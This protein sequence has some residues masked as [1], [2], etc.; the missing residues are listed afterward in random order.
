MKANITYTRKSSRVKGSVIYVESSIT[1]AAD[2]FAGKHGIYTLR[3]KSAVW[4]KICRM[5]NKLNAQALND[6]FPEAL[7]IKFSHKAGC[8]C[9]CSPGFRLKCK[10]DLHQ[11]K[12][13]WVDLEATE[14]E[15]AAFKA[16]LSPLVEKLEEEKRNAS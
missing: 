15:V 11:G 1:K 3:F 13:F 2:E 8:S 9:G 4:T 10:D 16:Q 5:A 14:D 7:T 12:D 6:L